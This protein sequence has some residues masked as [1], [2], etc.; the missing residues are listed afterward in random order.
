[1]EKVRARVLEAVIA[2]MRHTDSVAIHSDT[3]EA[4][5]RRIL[6][7]LAGAGEIKK[8]IGRSHHTYLPIGGEIPVS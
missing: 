8:I 2:G 4:Y 3:S 1:M 7:E 5:C 6:N